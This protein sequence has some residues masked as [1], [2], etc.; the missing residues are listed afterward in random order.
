MQEILNILYEFLFVGPQGVT[1]GIAP[2]LLGPIISGGASILGSFLGGGSARKAAERAA[3]E[4]AR[5]QGELETLENN[6]QE[7]INPYEGV[8]DLSSMI[9][10]PFDKIGV[11]TQAAEMQAEEA[12][13][14]LANTLDTLRST[15]A[16][17]G[18]ATALAQAAL[19]SKKGVSA[20]IEQQEAK[21]E[22]LKAQGE[23]QQ[24][25]MQMAEAQRM[26]QADVLGREFVY[27]QQERRDT[28]KLNR[29]Q[30]QITGSAS[31]QAMYNN[32]AAQGSAAVM[33]ALGSVG[34]AVGS[35]FA[36]K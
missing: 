16:S 21:N 7:I 11:A 2:A 8:T 12:D 10:N 28:Q 6:R 25:Q 32:Q 5:L 33:G 23:A 31:E 26:Q 36:S 29:L 22:Q 20:S 4:K 1:L 18:G 13:I 35:Y 27:G 17:A 15:G 9:E 24:Q 3:Q 19:R 34:G 30:A 14:A